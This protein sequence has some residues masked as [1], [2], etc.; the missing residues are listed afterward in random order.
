MSSVN[1]PL[2]LIKCLHSN[3]LPFCV[4]R[5]EN[6]WRWMRLNFFTF[7]SG[8]LRHKFIYKLIRIV[9]WDGGDLINGNEVNFD[10]LL[11]IEVFSGKL[12]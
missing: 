11:Q 12:F 3:W 6:W 4:E 7:S 8:F 1:D 9:R 5:K 2:K 10:V